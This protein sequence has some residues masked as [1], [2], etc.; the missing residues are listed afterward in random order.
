MKSITKRIFLS[1]L[2][3]ALVICLLPVNASAKTKTTD[4]KKKLY[5]KAY[6]T[7]GQLLLD[8]HQYDWDMDYVVAKKT[9]KECIFKL[10]YDNPTYTMPIELKVRRVGSGTRTDYTW[11]NKRTT[12]AQ[13]KQVLK[14][15]RVKS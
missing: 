11:K 6:T 14:K 3:L 15:Y 10:T 5:N 9:K 1:L 2:T 8:A 13:I 12:R 7:T 4:W